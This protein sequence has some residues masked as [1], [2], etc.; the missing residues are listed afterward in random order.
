MGSSSYVRVDVKPIIEI[1]G[2]L[3]G[4]GRSEWSCPAEQFVG[5][6]SLGSSLST[7]GRKRRIAK[8]LPTN[9][10]FQNGIRKLEVVEV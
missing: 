7:V 2:G 4:E 1:G 9:L 8:T 10:D 5:S 3:D 6:K